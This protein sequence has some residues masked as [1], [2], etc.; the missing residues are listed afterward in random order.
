MYIFYLFLSLLALWYFAVF[1]SYRLSWNKIPNAKN[2]NDKDFVSVLV[3]CRN[4][5][6]SITNLIQQIKNQNFDK[7][8]FELIVVNDHSED[9]TLQILEK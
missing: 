6:R 4:E 8:R 1:F 7:E 2:K 9:A 5:A 3:A